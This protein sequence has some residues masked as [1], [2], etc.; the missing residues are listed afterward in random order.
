MLDRNLVF[1]TGKGGV[2]KSAVAAGLALLAA[3]SGQRVLALAL[4]DPIGLAAHLR[5]ERIGYAPAEVLGGVHLAAVDRS[6]ALDEYLKLQLHVPQAAPTKQLTRAL[7]VLVDTA[8]GIRE[9]VSIGKPIYEVWR[10]AWDLVVVDAP[11][12]GQ[13]ESYLRAPEA[14]KALVPAG[15]VQEQAGRLEKT[16]TAPTTGLVIVTTPNE[17]PVVETIE[18]LE[19]LRRD[20]AIAPP[21]V[22]ANRTLDPLGLSSKRLA[23]VPA[24]A[25]RDAAELHL[26][27]YAEQEL[28]LGR[29]DDPPRIPFLFGLITPGEV[30]ARLADILGEVWP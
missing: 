9:I 4:T 17:L 12:T 20:V 5:A 26:H 27:L 29:L 6:R 10:E 8:P 15:I 13:I 22:I 23:A 3:R 19:A 11:P 7:N 18:A 16:L 21:Q 28:W 1:V 30:A 2:G 24:G 14:I 25:A